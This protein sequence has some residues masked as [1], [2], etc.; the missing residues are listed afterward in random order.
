[1]RPALVGSPPDQKKERGGP[2]EGVATEARLAR[3][4]R[5]APAGCRVGPN[6]CGADP[7]ARKGLEKPEQRVTRSGTFGR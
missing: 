2:R 4:V 5:L 3:T 6:A 7:D 1:M